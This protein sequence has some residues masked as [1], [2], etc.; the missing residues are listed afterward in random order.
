M[1]NNRK[2]LK[3]R[4]ST[5]TAVLL[6]AAM[7]LGA[8]FAWNDTRQHKTNPFSATDG[9]AAGVEI[10]DVTLINPF[11]PPEQWEWS[12]SQD[13]TTPNLITVRNMESSTIHTFVRLSL[14]QYM[15]L[16]SIGDGS[17]NDH[18]Y[19][20]EKDQMIL[21][22]THATGSRRGQ[23]MTAD[24]AT[25]LG[26]TKYG[27]YLV[28]VGG[29]ETLYATTNHNEIR[30][31]IY[32]KPM[33]KAKLQA[34][35]GDVPR[36]TTVHGPQTPGKGE[37]SYTPVI[38]DTTTLAPVQI[39]FADVSKDDLQELDKYVAIDWN[40]ANMMTFEEWADT[41]GNNGQ[42]VAKWIYDD[43]KAANST[44]QEGWVY[45]GAPLE[46]TQ[47]TLTLIN[48]IK[49]LKGVGPIKEG[50]DGLSLIGQVNYMLH[51]D[52]EAVS[53][54]SDFNNDGTPKTSEVDNIFK[55]T[56]PTDGTTASMD[57]RA[58]FFDKMNAYEKEVF[59]D[60]KDIRAGKRIVRFNPLSTNPGTNFKP[61]K[62]IDKPASGP[63]VLTFDTSMTP[64]LTGKTFV[65]WAS[66]EAK[67]KSGTADVTTYAA[68]AFTPTT[69]NLTEDITTLFAVYTTP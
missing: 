5:V 15:E 16:T 24:E 48:N 59:E 52:M 26:Y 54:F 66:T 56:L 51:T 23:Y 38:K 14:K 49:T 35:W 46:Q 36:A 6:A 2:S 3:K 61:R 4:V 42:W 32:G 47:E 13:L 57:A 33:L 27:T 30:N 19:L 11:T 43:S 22:A 62:V 41:A 8:T 65:G 37:C 67:A 18:F 12:E 50:F 63:H 69:L 60:R 68:G 39:Q 45:W 64:T 20:D 25:A 1:Q 34:R 58:K 28:S 44:Q 21:F 29:V 55:P 7:L 31:G 9:G 53:G 40:A 17:R 10:R